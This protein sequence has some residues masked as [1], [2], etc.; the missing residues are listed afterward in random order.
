MPER[1]AKRGFTLVELLI[2][3]LI[4]GALIGLL[5]PTIGR[6]IRTVH[7]TITRRTISGIGMGLEAYKND[8]GDYPPSDDDTNYPRTGAEKLVFYLR[9]PQGSGWGAGAAGMLP[10]H[11][12][13][14]RS[15]TRTYGPYYEA[16]ED[17]IKW[18]EVRGDWRR[19]AFLDANEPPG[20]IIY[21]KAGRDRD[22]NTTYDWNDNNLRSAPDAQGK[23]NYP[24]QTAFEDWT[25]IG[26][27]SSAADGDYKRHD[28]LLVSPGQ[29]GRFGGVRRDEDGNVFVATRQ[30]VEDGDAAYDD[31]TNWN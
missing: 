18:E 31:I 4:I 9:G 17:D 11:V 6:A 22:G 25:V 24:N 27:H 10:Q 8:F 16:D 7:S 19:V 2:V 30:Q 23:T 15:R 5:V 29:D 12:G 13:A 20:R 21:F 26:G 1:P 14:S 28:Y 3:M